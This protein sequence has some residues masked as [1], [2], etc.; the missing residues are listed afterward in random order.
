M[1]KLPIKNYG[2]KKAAETFVHLGAPHTKR[3]KTRDEILSTS[4]LVVDPIDSPSDVEPFE[5]RI[6]DYCWFTPEELP[7]FVTLL[8]HGLDPETFT[9]SQHLDPQERIACYYFQKLPTNT[10]QPS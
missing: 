5:A 4:Y 3:G 1:K 8:S 10:P 7:L 6:I 2:N 9:R